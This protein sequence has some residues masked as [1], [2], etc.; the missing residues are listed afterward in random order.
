MLT[1]KGEK[2]QNEGES[3]IPKLLNT[4]GLFGKPLP[5]MK[6]KKTS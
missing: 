6:L 1:V 3:R 4:S 2:R 5:L